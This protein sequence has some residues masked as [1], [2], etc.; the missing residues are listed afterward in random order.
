MH[1]WWIN[2]FCLTVCTATVLSGCQMVAEP[3]VLP[4]VTELPSPDI[5]ATA[6]AMTA[7]PSATPSAPAT[8]EQPDLLPVLQEYPV[9]T[10]SRPHDVAP[11]V[12][13]GVW[14]TAQG[15]GE[16][17]WLDPATGETRHVTLG[18]AGERSA[19]H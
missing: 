19:P 6:L 14:Y 4:P 16:L 11:A 9:P 15:S 2:L 13:G 1:Y 8:S 7:G 18:R 3:V 10:G 17:G 12:D 5:A